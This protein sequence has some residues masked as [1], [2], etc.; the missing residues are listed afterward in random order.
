MA[1]SQD[2]I[3]PKKNNKWHFLAEPYLMFPTMNGTAGIGNLPDA[4]F[5]L[6]PGDIFSHLQVGGMLYLEAQNDKWAITTDLLYMKLKEDIPATTII[7]S[8]NATVSELL[9][10]VTGFYKIVSWLD[11]KSVV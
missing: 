3:V 6:N 8:G 10:E 2:T 1:Q 7:I 11:R 5:N 4:S 9:W